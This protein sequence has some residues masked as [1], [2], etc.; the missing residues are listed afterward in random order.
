MK[1]FPLLVFD[2]DGTLVDSIERIVTSL[3]HAS[4]QAVKAEISE[5]Q[6]KDVIGLGLVEAIAQL[7]PELDEKHQAGKL[8]DIAD[9]YRHHYIHD[10]PVPAPH[11]WSLR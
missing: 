7:H 11:F 4:K 9:A 5:S 6:A 3:Q 1:Q 2:W 10:N 8:D